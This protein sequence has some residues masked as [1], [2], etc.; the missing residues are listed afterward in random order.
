MNPLGIN[1]PVSKTRVVVAMSGGVDSSVT[2]AMLHEQGYEVVGVT[3]QLY[4]HGAAIQKKGACCAGRDIYDAKRVAEKCGFKHYVLNYESKFQESVIEDFVDSYLKG[5]TP[6]PCIRCNQTVKF[7]DLLKMAKDLEADVMATGHY[8]RRVVG[9][10]G[11]AELHEAIDSEGKDQSYFLFATT[12]EQLEFLRF[13]LGGMPK[14]KTREKAKELGLCV[15][16]KPDSQDIC[17]VPK[18]GY[19]DIVKKM[20]PDA[21]REG[22]IVHIDGRTIGKHK[23]I[24][25]YTIGQRRGLGVGGGIIENNEPI[26]VVAI[27]ADKNEVI[28]G[29]YSALAKDIVYIQDCNWLIGDIAKT[30]LDVEV[31]LRSTQPKA[32]AKLYSNS[33]GAYIVLDESQFGIAV[34]QACVCYMDTRIIGGGWIEYSKKQ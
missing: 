20:R 12:Q 33:D 14:N 21:I 8:I 28:V 1:K 4:D 11:I 30:G 27:D 32:K 18:G 26:Y 31:K 2:A 19:A 13:P 34:G 10:D 6:I 29:P 24:I 15:A 9:S 22:N 5:E 23:G 16:D 7:N 17:F 3:M 25:N